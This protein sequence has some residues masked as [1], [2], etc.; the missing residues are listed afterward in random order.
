MTRLKTIATSR[1]RLL[2][3]LALVLIIIFYL[4]NDDPRRAIERKM[5]S[6][7][8]RRCKN[9]RV[10][11]YDLP[12]KYNQANSSAALPEFQTIEGSI[13]DIHIHTNLRMHTLIPRKKHH[14][15][16]NNVNG[17]KGIPFQMVT[18]SLK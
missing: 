15:C 14:E 8:R 3:L 13:L 4:N 2:L 9:K 1:T 16:D 7:I 18:V 12:S 11:I 17:G 10:Y 6:A 5:A